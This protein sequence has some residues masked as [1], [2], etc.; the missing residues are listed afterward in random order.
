MPGNFT[1]REDVAGASISI[2]TYHRNYCTECDWSA[3]TETQSRHEVARAAIDH[4]H[5][6][7]HTIESEPVPELDQIPL[8]DGR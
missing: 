2:V 5:E 1:I 8:N 7:L 3:S 6:T 4:F